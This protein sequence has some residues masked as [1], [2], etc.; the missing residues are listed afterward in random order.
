MRTIRRGQ[1]RI[2][3]R[4]RAAGRCRERRPARAVVQRRTDQPGGDRARLGQDRAADA[5]ARVGP[6]G[7]RPGVG[8][9]PQ[10]RRARLQRAVRRARRQA[11]VPQGAREAPRRGADIRLLR[12]EERRRH[13]D[14]ALHPPGRRLAAVHGR[15][16][17]VVERPGEA[18]RRPRQVAAE[19]H[20]PHARLDR[21]PRLDPRPDAAVPR[22]RP[23]RRLARPDDRQRA[24]CAGCRD[25][26]RAG[27]RRDARRPRRVEGGR[28]TSATTPP[29]S[30]SPSRTEPARRSRCADVSSNGDRRPLARRA[31]VLAAATGARREAAH[32]RP[33]RRAD[34]RAPRAGGTR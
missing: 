21:P 27:A 6:L 20:D 19:L 9:G 12:V 25:R 17:R 15:A 1:C 8:E 34:A 18:R 3:A 2:R 11:D 33:R 30:S 26:R 13:E 23:R 32:A 31:A 24:R 29:S 10:D 28:A 4:R 22:R 5:A 14:P 7:S 16:V